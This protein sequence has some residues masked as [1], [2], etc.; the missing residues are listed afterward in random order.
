M[1]NRID[2]RFS[3]LKLAGKKAFIAYVTAGDPS[4]KKTQEL[5]PQLERS[6]VDILEI[7][8]PFSDPLADGPVIQAASQ[9][10]LA[11]KTTL[12]K[13]LE[14]TRKARVSAPHLPIVYMSYL[15]PILSYGIRRFAKDARSAGVDGVIIPDLPPEEGRAVSADL[16][17]GGLDLIYLL[18][19]TS[20]L[21][22]Q[23]MIAQA[24]RGFVYFVS[25]TGVTGARTS[26]STEALK[27]VRQLRAKTRRPVCL[28]FGVSTPEQA[29]DA[30]RA[31]DGVIVGS[32]IVKALS[33]N[34]GMKAELFCR[35]FIEP[36]AR[37]AGKDL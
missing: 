15:N 10:A 17:H 19:P 33:K 36:L 21:K 37:A 35:R 7:G 23:R 14:M 5:I 16:S 12:R 1:T 3:D 24:S 20:S 11:R 13:I 34:A 30:A 2:K 25:L 22:R 4:L 32:A 28:G 6:G 18:A 9:R 8:I 29:R 26:L 31:S 27:M